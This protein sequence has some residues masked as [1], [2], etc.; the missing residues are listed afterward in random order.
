MASEYGKYGADRAAAYPTPSGSL[1]VSTSGS[2]STGAGTVAAPYRTIKKAVA[3][4][5]AGG[6]IAIRGGSYHE[7]A[8]YPQ[9][10]VADSVLIPVDKPGLTIQNYNGEEVWLDGSEVVSGWA[11]YDTNK[12]RAAVAVTMHRSPSNVRGQDVSGYGSYLLAEYPIAHWPEMLLIDGVRQTQ[13]QTLAEVVPGTFFVEGSITGTGVDKHAFTSTHYVIGTDPAGKEVRVAK[14]ARAMTCAADNFTL[15]GVGFRRYAPNLADLGVFFANARPG[16]FMENVTME[17]SSNLGMDIGSVGWTFR[18][19]TILRCG[20]LGI[21][22]SN[23]AD[24]GLMEWC[25][26]EQ[27]NDRRFN[28]GPSG[29]IVKIGMA[30]DTTVRYNRFHDNRGHGVW[31]DE[32]CYRGRIY[33]NFITDNYGIGILYEISARPWIVDNIIVNNGVLSND[34]VKRKPHDNPAIDIKSSAHASIWHNTIIMPEAA[35]RFSEGYRKP[36]NEDGVSWRSTS[37]WGSVFGQDK[38]RSHQFYVDAG[39]EDVWQF[40]RDEMNWDN[41]G[42]SYANNVLA[43][44]AGLSTVYSVFLSLYCETGLKGAVEMTGQLDQPNVYARLD[45]TTPQRFANSIKRVDGTAPSPTVAYFNM[46]GNGH[47]GSPSWSATM[48]DTQSTLTT[49]NVVADDRQWLLDRDTVLKTAPVATPP[50]EV[51]A[52]LNISPFTDT[53][54]GAGDPVV[55]GATHQPFRDVRIGEEMALA[56]YIGD[57]QAWPTV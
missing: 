13:V 14:L 9:D 21:N 19:G 45:G 33:G 44:T 18:K 20:R 16:L 3:E 41:E 48:N 15:R 47:E 30:W 2:D 43:G 54:I 12:Y 22:A 23:R 39:F 42:V 6:T 38:S 1:I 34:V 37:Q 17:D 35:I 55:P 27:T 28:Y 25:Y 8:L 24:G 57:M 11:S 31:Y 4:V 29:G 53:R 49:T 5:A 52:L 51:R 56:L 36:L 26:A 10:L 40:Y 32:C 46:T 50:I 7:G